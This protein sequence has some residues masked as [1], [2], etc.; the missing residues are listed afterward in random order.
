MTDDPA[1][2]VF[3]WRRDF[4]VIYRDV[5]E[6]AVQRHLYREIRAELEAG[7]ERFAEMDGTVFDWLRRMHVYSAVIAIRKQMENDPRSV[8]ML[9]LLQTIRPRAARLTRADYVARAGEL[10]TNA[11][12][13]ERLEHELR[14][15]VLNE[16]FDGLAGAGEQ[17]VTEASV[18]RDIDQLLAAARALAPYVQWTIAH[19]DRRGIGASTTTTWDDLNGAIDLLEQLVRRYNELLDAGHAPGLVPTWQHDWKAPLRIPWIAQR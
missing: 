5:Q 13:R 10:P 8:S 14:G 19:R 1:R 12:E 17:H 7:E 6:L 2:E 16:R 15:E 9:R 18:Q 3:A 11:T 4:D